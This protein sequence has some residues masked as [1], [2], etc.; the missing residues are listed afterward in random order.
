M[1]ELPEVETIARALREGGRGG[2]SLLGLRVLHVQVYW[3]RSIQIP[4]VKNFKQKIAN[5]VIEDIGRRGKFLVFQLSDDD[6]LVHLRMSGDLRVETI[7][8]N[9]MT[10]SVGKHDRV[11][12]QLEK[13]FRLVFEDTRKFGRVWLVPDAEEVVGH[14][15]PEPFD[16][17]LDS[18]VFF[19]YLT[20]KKRMIKPLL[21]DQNF[22]AGMGN[23]YTDEALFLAGI[24]PQTRSDRLTTEQAGCLLSSIRIVLSKGIDQNGAS[25][26]WVYRGG[27]F[28][29]HF[30]VYGRTGKEC[31]TCGHAIERIR[32]GQRSSH[33]CPVCQPEK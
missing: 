2:S 23:I 21:L 6:L 28:Q 7:Q 4:D 8:Q 30:Q 29:N 16:P 17:E 1:P 25:I 33:F 27:N 12:F 9:G 13:D 20:S 15:G 3:D 18:G 19:Q 31:Y 10:R 24:H 26:D 32:V 5:Q 11:V 22:L 14:L